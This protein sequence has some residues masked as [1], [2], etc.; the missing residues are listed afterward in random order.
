[1]DEAQQILRCVYASARSRLPRPY[2]ARRG[3]REQMVVCSF[4][5]VPRCFCASDVC[6]SA[7]F[8]RFADLALKVLEESLAVEKPDDQVQGRTDGLDFCIE[9]ECTRRCFWLIQ[10]MSWISGIYIYKPMRPRS[11]EMTK[12][13]R[14]PIDETTFDLAAH[15]SSAS[16]YCLQPPRSPIA[17][18]VYAAVE[19]LHARAPTTRYASQFGHVLRILSI[20]QT[21]QNVIGI[22][23]SH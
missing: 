12:K 10:C 2:S 9:R 5:T 15:W 16:E 18:I 14:L 7:I 19:Y 1:M 20:Y 22:Y 17:Y 11:L 23:S 21:V 3:R 8:A 4:L 13:I 6:L